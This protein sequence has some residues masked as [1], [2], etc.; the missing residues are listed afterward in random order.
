MT[1]LSKEIW[2]ILISK[3]IM[4]TVEYQPSSLNKVADL[5]SR[6]KVDSSE[7]V[8]TVDMSFA[9]LCLK[10][11]TPT[12]DLFPSRM[13]HQVAQYV[14]WKPLQRSRGRNVNSL[15]TGSLLRI[16]LIL[17][18]HPCTKQ[19]TPRSRTHTTL[20]TP[21]WQTQLWYPQMLGMLIRRLI[22]IP[23]SATLLVDPKRNP[24]PLVLNKALY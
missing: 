4:I 6:R 13:S 3:Q 20:I 23:N 10:S 2:E 21:C 11:G 24:H 18:D 1:I 22:L 19:N 14:A 15:D 7:W 5:E 12:V 9:N 16:S 8:S 17:Y